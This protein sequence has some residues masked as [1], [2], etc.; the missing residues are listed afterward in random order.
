MRRS[1]VLAA[2][3]RHP[4]GASS[5]LSSHDALQH[6]AQVARVQVQP[7]HRSSKANSALADAAHSS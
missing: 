3:R 5:A 1:A 4:S 7:A 6:P 2:V